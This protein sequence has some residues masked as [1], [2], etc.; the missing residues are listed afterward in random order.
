MSIA[1]ERQ[2]YIAESKDVAHKH[3]EESQML[4]CYVRER[5][6]SKRA[7]AGCNSDQV[8]AIRSF[9]NLAGANVP[10]VPAIRIINDTLSAESQLSEEQGVA[11]YRAVRKNW[12]SRKSPIIG[13]VVAIKTGN[14]TADAKIGC[15]L[16]HENDKFNRYIGI[17]KALA[18]LE[19]VRV[20][21]KNIADN[22]AEIPH[23]LKRAVGEMMNRAARIYNKSGKK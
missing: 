6:P 19:N 3:F 20:L 21:E 17:R 9:L 16:C 22:T 5:R 8:K 1:P 23:T 4:V 15:S 10:P 14:G 12:L 18:T 11:I 13:V 7:P 2:K